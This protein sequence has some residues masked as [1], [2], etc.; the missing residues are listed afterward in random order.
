M[1]IAPILGRYPK[2]GAAWFA[3]AAASS[4]LR[5]DLAGLTKAKMPEGRARA[6]SV[7]RGMKLPKRSG[8]GEVQVPVSTGAAP[9]AD[10][11]GFH[12]VLYFGNHRPQPLW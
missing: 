4:A 5:A 10:R 7:P 2:S 9:S 6:L 11:V 3:G 12:R 8:D 1:F